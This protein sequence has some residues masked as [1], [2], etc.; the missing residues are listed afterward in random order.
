[1]ADE[2]VLIIIPVF[3]EGAQTSLTVRAL[4]LAGYHRIVLVDDGSSDIDLAI[5]AK[6]HAVHLV[7]HRVNLG[8]GA[9]IQT[10]LN[11]A[12]DLGASIVITFDADGQHNASDIPA[13]LEPLRNDMA[14]IALGSRFLAAGKTA[15]PVTRAFILQLARVVNFMFAGMW[16]SDAHNGLRALNA[17]AIAAINLSENGM[18]HASELLLE[19]K[20]NKLRFTEVPVDVSYSAH[21]RQKGQSSMNGVRILFQLI[22]HKI[23]R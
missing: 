3:N 18:A 7:R 21:S 19:I 8:Q 6:S 20:N 23:F 22:L 16:L 14:D 1:M 5:V 13:L 11:F 9:A 10:G 12:K 4:Q 17:R 15:T 2:N